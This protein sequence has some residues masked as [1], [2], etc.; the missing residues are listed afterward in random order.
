MIYLDNIRLRREREAHE[1]ERQRIE[2]IIKKSLPMSVKDFLALRQSHKI[3]DFEG[4]YILI[5]ESI[6]KPYIGQSIHVVSRVNNHFTGHGNPDVYVDYRNNAP[7]TI[8]LVKYDKNEFKSLNAMEKSLISQYSAFDNG[9][10]R[11]HGNQG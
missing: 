6:N 11:T 10:N 3:D 8:R 4:C 1:K 5:N 9:Y 7:F 2:T